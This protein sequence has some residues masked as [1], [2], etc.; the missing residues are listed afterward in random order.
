MA[1]TL[2]HS[3]FFEINIELKDFGLG[4]ET[5]NLWLFHVTLL[6]WFSGLPLRQF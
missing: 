1:T 3:T 5:L 2:G 6:S 4:E